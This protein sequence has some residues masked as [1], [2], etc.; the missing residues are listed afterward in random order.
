MYSS[1]MFVRLAFA[2]Q[3]HIDASVVIIDEALAVGD[4]FFRQKC[5]ARLAQLREAGAAIL[6]VSHSMPE[7]EQYCDRAMLLEQ[8]VPRFLGRATEATKHFYLLHQAGRAAAARLPSTG[9]IQGPAGQAVADSVPRPSERGI[10]LT[11]VTQI[12]TARCTFIALC[13]IAGEPR[14][15]FEQ[16]ET[17]V[18]HY[19][20]ALNAAGGVPV[21]GLLFRDQRGIIVHGKNSWQDDRGVVMGRHPLSRVV[22][23]QAVKLDLAPGEYTF[24]IGLAVVSEPDWERRKRISHEEMSAAYV[25]LCQLPSVSSFSV[26]MLSADGVATLTHH[27][28][29]DL[30]TSISVTT[31]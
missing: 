12:G 9:L 7:I 4:V 13:G 17:A 21:C 15:V 30:P 10:D 16:G 27:G 25:S 29:A 11:E 23:R 20:F 3:A 31:D 26:R 8:G 28:V 6:L 22:C 5:Y 19:E 14:N 18:F 2:V 1:W 24:E